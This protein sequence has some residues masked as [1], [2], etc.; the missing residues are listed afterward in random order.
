MSPPNTAT[1]SPTKKDK[2]LE[3][4]GTGLSASQIATQVGANVQYVQGVI[5]KEKRDSEVAA[6]TSA[7][8]EVGADKVE[9]VG[10]DMA[11]LR[12]IIIES[13]PTKRVDAVVRA[14][15]KNHPDDF[16]VLS[17]LLNRA[18]VPV[19][20]AAFILENYASH[21]GQNLEAEQVNEIMNKSNSTK[22][23]LGKN[24]KSG[25][26][27]KDQLDFMD[28]RLDMLRKR[29]LVKDMM[30]SL[31]PPEQKQQPSLVKRTK[32]VFKYNEKGEMMTDASGAPI[33]DVIEEQVPVSQAQALATNNGGS[34]MM[35]LMMGQLT[36]Q[37]NQNQQL[38]A[39]NQKMFLEMM[40]GIMDR[41][42]ASGDGGS[43]AML[44]VLEKDRE[45]QMEKM[46][47][48]HVQQ[49]EELKKQIEFRGIKD[50]YDGMIGGL[51]EEI[52]NMQ[53][54]SMSD[55]RFRLQM[56]TDLTKRLL[57]EA[58]GAKDSVGGA[59][60]TLAKE[61]AEDRRHLRHLEQMRAAKDMGLDPTEFKSSWETQR[62]P[63]IDDSEF[64]AKMSDG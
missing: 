60:G 63:E 36:N 6:P 35:A 30:D 1:G 2:I 25:D 24:T 23:Y 18:Q 14:F 33:Y 40:K 10:S 54:Q 16:V 50:E 56:Q 59:I 17:K 48:Q 22:N 58:S 44:K 38:A 27:A 8:A 37:Q 53:G 21:R 4:V 28:T 51:Q 49:M 52:K 13:S 61:M 7:A 9:T 47:T 31:N 46:N 64:E 12:N 57:D 15:G 26:G 45:L 55:E 62:V 19:A 32:R 34:D 42:Q 43:A 29:T 39:D 20:D 11:A 41:P 5:R 3:L